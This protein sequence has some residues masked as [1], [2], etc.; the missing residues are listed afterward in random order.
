MRATLQRALSIQDAHYGDDHC[1]VALTLWYFSNALGARGGDPTAMRAVLQ[2]SL[3]LS[4]AHCGEGHYAVAAT[5]TDLGGI[6]RSGIMGCQERRQLLVR[7]QWERYAVHHHAAA[8][9]RCHWG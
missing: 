5:L 4:E 8:R 6:P 9:V 3:S 7:W 2:Q 1:R